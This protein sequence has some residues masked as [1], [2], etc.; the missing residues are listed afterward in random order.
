MN[1]EQEMKAYF[2]GWLFSIDYERNRTVST[3]VPIDYI[4]S[5][6]PKCTMDED[7]SRNQNLGHRWSEVED[8]TLLEM[9][10]AGNTFREIGKAMAMSGSAAQRRH[11]D[12]MMQ[13]G[14]MP[15]KR[16]FKPLKFSLELEARVVEMRDKGMGFHE[17][18][19]IVGIGRVQANELYRRYKLRQQREAA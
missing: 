3:S 8:Q 6:K 16:R 7:E 9:R 1:I 11:Q 17:I 12:L 10:R 14:Y 15:P 4:P 18:A 13:Q 19:P 2:D 5:H